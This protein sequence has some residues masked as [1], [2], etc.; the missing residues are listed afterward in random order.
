MFPKIQKKQFDESA[1]EVSESVKRFAKMNSVCSKDSTSE[2]N[3]IRCAN[4]EKIRGRVQ[5]SMKEVMRN[6]SKLGKVLLERAKRIAEG[7]RE[8]VKELLAK[9]KDSDLLEKLKKSNINLDDLKN[10]F[11]NFGRN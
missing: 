3:K 5:Q 4:F 1:K 8:K 2:K 7:I 6:S 10:R 11:K 9:L